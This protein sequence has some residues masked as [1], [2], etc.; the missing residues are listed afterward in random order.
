MNHV[1]YVS[2]MYAKVSISISS[3]EYH[4]IIDDKDS[5]TMPH[6]PFMKGLMKQITAHHVVIIY[7]V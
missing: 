1:V 2:M 5:I 6:C 3:N 7:V 4:M